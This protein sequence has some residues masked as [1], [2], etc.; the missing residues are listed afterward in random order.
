[1]NIEVQQKIVEYIQSVRT[2]AGQLQLEATETLEKAK[3]DVE[4]M[5]ENKK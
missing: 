4:N 2:K 5:I 1:V 3:R